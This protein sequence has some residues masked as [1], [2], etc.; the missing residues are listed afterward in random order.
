[1]TLTTQDRRVFRRTVRTLPLSI[2]DPRD[3]LLLA[4]VAAN[5][6]TTDVSPGGVHARVF[7]F[8]PFAPG[9]PVLIRLLAPL[10]TESTPHGP[11]TT[12]LGPSVTARGTVLRIE[13]LVVHEVAGW[14]IAFRF[15]EEPE[16]APGL[17]LTGY[18]RES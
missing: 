5:L 1:M 4:P 15:D 7:D 17:G 10:D 9:D 3:L 14:G 8:V 16:V 12:V 11:V 2:H 18:R 13:R 6:Q